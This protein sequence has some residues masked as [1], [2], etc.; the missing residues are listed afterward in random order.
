MNAFMDIGL[1]VQPAYRVFIVVIIYFYCTLT[2]I[3]SDDLKVLKLKP[4]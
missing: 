4:F 2:S 1:G 3:D